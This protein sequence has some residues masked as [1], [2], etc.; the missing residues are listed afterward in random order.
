[1][2]RLGSYE[3]ARGIYEVRS[4]ELVELAVFSEKLLVLAGII[5]KNTE[6]S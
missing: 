2:E 5:P 6:V 1:M 3:T 4:V